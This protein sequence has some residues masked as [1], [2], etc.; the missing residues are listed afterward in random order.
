MKM[1]KKKFLES[2]NEVWC[3][4]GVT[5]HGVGVIAIRSIPEGTDPFRNCDRF[6]GTLRISER[7]LAAADA[8]RVVKEM[9]RDFCAS[10][11]GYHHVPDYGIDAIDKSY[12]LNH[13]D[14]PNVG[15]TDGHT[16]RTL[17]RIRKGEEL[18]ADYAAYYPTR[19]AAMMRAA[20]KKKRS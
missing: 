16:F 2:L 11:D 1:T 12:F 9:V 10:E 14:D 15:T 20:G 17:R 18:R 8:P 3:R 13:S 5:P 19:R 4:L 6:G 7:E